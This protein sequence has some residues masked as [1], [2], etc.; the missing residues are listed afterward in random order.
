MNTNDLIGTIGVGL[1]LLAYFL[2]IFSWIKKE[3]VLFYVM[4]IVGASIACFASILIS[5]WPFIILE[6]TWAIVSVIG[7]MKSIKKPQA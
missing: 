7:L 4:N 6:G 5:F 1:I 3:G 2:N